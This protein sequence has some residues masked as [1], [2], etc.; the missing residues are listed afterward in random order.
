MFPTIPDGS[1]MFFEA[2]REAVPGD[3][4][5]VE[6][7]RGLLAHRVTAIF[8]GGL[9]TWGDW[10]RHPDTV[11]PFSRVKGRCVLVVR[12]GQ[13]ISMDWPLMRVFNRVLAFVLPLV[14]DIR[15]LR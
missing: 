9:Q 12:K 3:I 11:C 7:Q 1:T 15:H 8:R 10:N 6:S 14:K 13:P 4:V 2:F 5:L